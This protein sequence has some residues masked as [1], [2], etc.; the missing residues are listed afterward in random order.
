[1]ICKE[2]FQFSIQNGNILFS[3][4]ICSF[5]CWLPMLL[6][7]QYRKVFIVKR[8][9]LHQQGGQSCSWRCRFRQNFSHL[10]KKK[11]CFIQDLMWSSFSFVNREH[12]LPYFMEAG[13]DLIHLCLHKVLR[14]L[15]QINNVIIITLII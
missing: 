1:M 4:C 2:Q 12:K 7:S 11:Y 6:L 8:A 3:F 15:N 14:I 10:L 13:W 5:T 9:V